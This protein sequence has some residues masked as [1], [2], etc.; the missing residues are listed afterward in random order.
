M[1]R[2]DHLRILISLAG[3]NSKPDGGRIRAMQEELE[4]VDRKI[5]RNR[6]RN[7]PQPPITRT[8]AFI[9]KRG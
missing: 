9:P 1:D 5:A 4:D 6:D 7:S 8:P 2:R 3:D